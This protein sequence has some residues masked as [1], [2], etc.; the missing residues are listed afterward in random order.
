M[1]AA[2][3]VDSTETQNHVATQVVRGSLW[4]LGGQG[5]ILIASLLATPFTIRL[6]G[7]ESYG[8][9]TLFNVLIS[10]LAFADLGM[11][12]ASTRFASESYAR[13][14]LREETSIVWTCALLGL[15]PVLFVC[16]IS[17]PL[18]PFL[19]DHFF[20]L[21][22]TPREAAILALRIIPLAFVARSLAGIFNTPQIVRLRLDS[23]SLITAGTS[24]IQ[25]LLAPVLLAQGGGLVALAVLL[26]GMSILTA[27]LHL[28]VARRLVPA[29]FP[30]RIQW[31]SAKP[32]LRF[33]GPIVASY[34]ASMILMNAEKILLTTFA[35]MS[36]LAHYSV[37][38]T[39]SSLLAI[40]PT[41]LGQ[42][43]YPALS[44]L[45]ADEDRAP[46]QKLY[47]RVVRG[48]LMWVLPVALVMCIGAKPF[49]TLWAGEE[50]GRASVVPFYILV[51]GLAANV[52][53]YAP[54][55]LLMALHKG[56]LLAKLNFIQLLPYLALMAVS[57]Y[58]F[59]IIG[60]ALIYSLRLFID[61]LIVFALADRYIA[62]SRP[63]LSG[64][65]IFYATA[66]AVLLMPVAFLIYGTTALLPLALALTLSLAIY[67]LLIWTKVLT[68]EEQGWIRNS[69]L[70]RSASQ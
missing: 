14:D 38:F 62:T 49:F 70:R 15:A 53:A 45:Q 19:V 55:N 40:I 5:A 10:S 27:L 20:H 41:A 42:S 44:R 2:I 58:Y 23:Y 51:I 39:F 6:L 34:V 30:P 54:N 9:F 13:N 3:Q 21:A 46:L 22:S 29:I 25:M 68:S 12:A 67:S 31:K 36:A 59:G 16:L 60:A 24:I 50:Y 11:G 35:S 33:G 17:F 69:L 8:I 18:A 32:L 61:A 56:H 57:T 37:A 48:N 47:V 43:L 64:E 28:L 52:L 1:A 63:F 26:S 65:R 66:C 7:T 4:N